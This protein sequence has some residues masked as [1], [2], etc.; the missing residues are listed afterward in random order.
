MKENL[1]ASIVLALGLVGAAYLVGSQGFNISTAPAVK[2]LST[3]AEGK[4]KIV[5]D[6]IV[7][8]A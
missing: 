5:P 7:I 4:V 2:T 3:T 1:L 8:S 6:T